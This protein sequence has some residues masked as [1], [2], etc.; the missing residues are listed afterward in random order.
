MAEEDVKPSVQAILNKQPEYFLLYDYYEGDHE[1]KFSTKK[2]A[3]AFESVGI[4]FAENWC[5]VIIDS[6]LDR[7]T[8]LGWTVLKDKEKTTRLSTFFQ[9]LHIALVADEVHEAANV[10]GEGF[11][12]M[13]K[14][15]G[16]LEAYANDPAW[17]HVFYDPSNPRKKIRAAK[18][19]MDDGVATLILY[20][21]DKIERYVASRPSGKKDQSLL[22]WSFTKDGEDIENSYGRIPVF[23]FR[24]SQSN[25]RKIDLDRAI[26]SMQDA[27]NIFFSN[28]MVANEFFSMKQRVIISMADPGDLKNKAGENWWIPAGEE[29]GPQPNVLQLDAANPDAFI[30]AMDRTSS[31]MGVV[32]RTPKHYFFSSGG[33]D[34]SGEALM[35]MESPLV[36]K[37]TKRKNNYDVTW[38]EVAAFALELM[39]LR[40]EPEN[41]QSQW[42]PIPTV[43]PLTAAQIVKTEGESGIPVK[44]SL[45][46]QGWSQEDLAQFDKDQAE[47]Q[48]K[49]SLALKAL[50]DLRD[51]GTDN[52]QPDGSNPDE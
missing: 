27:I 32:T 25:K 50:Q 43:Q 44:N 35:T 52:T 15:D 38:L 34:P 26:R 39:G 37:T 8:L 23:H 12:I 22:N 40:V 33:Q 48:K 31:A 30:K 1:L 47:A 46:R 41:I 21:P 20:Y 49:S 51:E 13:G 4:Y 29:G 28:M 3:K 5:A 24:N 19:Y 42:G 7:L 45:R 6:V 11:M 14:Q 2:L 18:L 16:F 17:T 36:K 10:V 9:N